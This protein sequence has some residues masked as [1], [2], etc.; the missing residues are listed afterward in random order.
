MSLPPTPVLAAIVPTQTIIVDQNLATLAQQTEPDITAL[1][2]QTFLYGI[3]ASVALPTV[4]TLVD[5]RPR[6]R[7][8]FFLLIST[9]LMFLLS[10]VCMV[11]E[12]VNTMGVLEGIKLETQG[13]FQPPTAWY[14]FRG[15]NDRTLVQ[16]TIFS[17]EFILGDAIVIWRAGA[18]WAFDWKIMSSMVVVL[19]GDFATTLYFI[20]CEG[21][22]D[23]WYIAGTQ[24]KSCNVSQRAMFFLS[25]GTNVVA[26]F[27]IALKAWQHREA[28]IAM[29]S[30]LNLSSGT[31][32]KTRSPAQK[33]M[34]LFLESG[35]LYMLYWAACS[36]T[37][38]PFVM[39][40]ESPAFFMTDI[41]NQTRYQVVGLYPTAIILLVHRQSSSWDTPEVAASLRTSFKAAPPPPRNHESKQISTF[42]VSTIDRTSITSDLITEPR[43]TI[44]EVDEAQVLKSYSSAAPNSVDEKNVD[45]TSKRMSSVLPMA[46]GPLARLSRNVTGIPATGHER[47]LSDETIAVVE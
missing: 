3:Y 16:A 9:I 4:L 45:D 6:S 27:F 46:P 13:A 41:F 39:G 33:I 17:L 7:P 40:I 25:F 15:A 22:G 21:K 44:E 23:W 8:W 35:F 32:K 30:S 47:S 26:T 31:W 10:T 34:I 11:L 24:P 2:C 14:G 36:F 42:G 28:F 5:R 20:G 18:L 1:V 43:Y 29:P 12:V 19:L 38:F 37:Y